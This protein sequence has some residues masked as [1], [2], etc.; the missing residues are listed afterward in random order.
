MP[1]HVE[2]THSKK[3]RIVDAHTPNSWRERLKEKPDRA[4]QDLIEERQ[5]DERNGTG[6][7]KKEITRNHGEGYHK[8]V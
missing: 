5:R 1:N 6:A 3:S 4:T 2:R 7:T 8:E